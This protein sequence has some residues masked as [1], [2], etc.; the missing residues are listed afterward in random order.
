MLER[1]FISGKHY[2]FYLVVLSS[3]FLGQQVIY[4]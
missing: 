2:G 4:C 1:K 3:I